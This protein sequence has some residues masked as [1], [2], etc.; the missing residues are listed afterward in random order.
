[1]KK[2]AFRPMIKPL[3]IVLLQ[4]RGMAYKTK[5]S[6]LRVLHT[7]TPPPP[8]TPTEARVKARLKED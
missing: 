7:R 8:P 6:T 3:K 1:M 5:Y 4:W 2:L